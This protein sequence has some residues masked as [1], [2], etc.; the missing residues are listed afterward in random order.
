MGM[1][2][3]VYGIKPADKKFK[4]MLAIWRMCEEQKIAPPKEVEDFFGDLD[5]GPDDSGVL[6]SIEESTGVSTY[7]NESQEGFEIDLTKFCKANPDIKILRFVN[8]W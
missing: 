6:V 5:D 1:S 3:C 8:S 4:A 2:T 7:G